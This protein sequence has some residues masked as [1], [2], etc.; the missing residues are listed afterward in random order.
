MSLDNDAQKINLSHAAMRAI[1]KTESLSP[2]VTLSS[3]EFFCMR[4]FFSVNERNAL[5]EAYRALYSFK[6]ISV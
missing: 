2:L 5:R 1:L 3:Q 6:K 4:I